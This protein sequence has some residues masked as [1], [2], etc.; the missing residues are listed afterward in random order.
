[1]WPEK[2]AMFAAKPMNVLVVLFKPVTVLFG[3]FDE[4]VSDMVDEEDKVTATEDELIDIVE[5][6]PSIVRQNRGSFCI[7]YSTSR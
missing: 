6:T 2:F 1:M 4:K 7:I 3:K 5:K